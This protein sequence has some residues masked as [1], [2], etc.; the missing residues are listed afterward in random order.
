[1]TDTTFHA[2]Q[3][4]A[5]DVNDPALRAYVFEVYLIAGAVD[6]SLLAFLDTGPGSLETLP[7]QALTD[8]TARGYVVVPPRDDWDITQD[9]ADQLL[10]NAVAPEND[11]V[12][13]LSLSVTRS[14]DGQLQVVETGEAE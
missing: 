8:L 6:M 4:I 11:G 5:H 9:I 7:T 13:S 14:S 10:S 12:T 1:M 3:V 2:R